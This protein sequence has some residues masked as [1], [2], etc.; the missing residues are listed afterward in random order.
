MHPQLLSKEGVVTTQPKS[1]ASSA[2]R[3]KGSAD[4]Q[5]QR[6][7]SV[8]PRGDVHIAHVSDRYR[9]ASV[10][11]PRSPSQAEDS[12]S[13]PRSRSLQV[14]PQAPFLTSRSSTP[15]FGSRSP[16]PG[17]Y[18]KP[19]PLS[20]QRRWL[21][22]SRSPSPEPVP[23]HKLMTTAEEQSKTRKDSGDQ[24]GTGSQ[25]HPL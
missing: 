10:S 2:Q 8:S 24:S 9:T 17:P 3:Q 12:P 22:V 19:A 21:T 11:P 7:R 18:I 4:T 15:S 13:R 5:V 25:E 16:S 23:R 20:K 1:T 14:S 6:M